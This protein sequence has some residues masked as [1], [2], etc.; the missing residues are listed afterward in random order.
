MPRR[1]PSPPV[2]VPPAVLPA[3]GAASQVPTPSGTPGAA[4][5]L[6]LRRE[7]AEAAGELRQRE[8]QIA[9]IEA[10]AGLG[11]WEQVLAP[12]LPAQP[13]TW[14]AELARIHGLEPGEA[15]TTFEAFLPLVHPEDRALVVARTAALSAAGEGGDELQYRVLRPDGELRVVR[16]RARIVPSG[17]GRPARMIGTSRD[18]TE[19]VAA[20]RALREREAQ[21]AEAQEIAALGHWEWD[22][23]ADRIAWSDMQFR[24]HGEEPRAQVT[25]AWFFG[26]VHPDDRAWMA[27][28]MERTLRSGEPFEF[29]YRIVRPSGEVRWL[30]AR[31]RMEMSAAGEPLRMVGT[32]QDITAQRQAEEA[33]RAGEER[34]RALFE[35]SNDAIL[36]TDPAS[37]EVVEANRRLLELCD[38]TL[39][40]LR[41]D[42]ARILWNGP[43]PYTPEVATDQARRAAAG[44]AQRFEW[45]TIQP[46]TGA[47]I[48]GEVSLQGLTLNGRALCLA[49]IRDIRARRLAEQALRESEES[50]R[51]IFDSS[52]DAVFVHEL[53]S[54]RVLDANRTACEMNGRTLAELR[55]GGL[56]LI[57]SGPP[58]FTPERALELIQKA[59]GGEAQR[60]EWCTYHAVTREEMWVEVSLQKVIIREQERLLAL[61]R[62]I[63]ERKQRERALRASEEAYRTIFE[64][65]SEGIW[66]HDAATGE[67]VDVNLAAA[68]MYGYTLQE[69]RRLTHEALNMPGSE[70]TP[71]RVAEYMAWAVAGETPRFEWMGRRKDG[72]AVWAEVTL[73]RV[74]VAGQ[75]RILAAA[76]DIT[77]RKA[78]EEALRQSEASYRN[79]FDSAAAGIWLHDLETGDFLDVNQTACEMYGYSVE[80]QKRVGLAGI[81]W[82]EP[83]YTVDDAWQY[84][85]R[86]IAGEPQR[87]PWRGRHRDGHEV[88]AEVTVRRETIGG[89][90][91]VLVTGRNIS[92]QKKAEDAL[93]RANE[94]LERRVAERTG[95]LAMLNRMLEQEIEE[96]KAAREELLTRTGELEAIFQT[97]PDLYFRLAADG[98]ILDYRTG[99][100]ALLLVSPQL[101]LGRRM[102]DVLPAEAQAA[103]LDGM[104][105]VAETGDMVCIEYALPLQDGAH[106]FEARL[107]PAGRGELVAVVRDITESKQAEAELVRQKAYFEQIIDS[108]DAGLAIFDATGRYEYVSPRAIPDPAV[109][110]WAIGKTIAEY[111]AY[112][113]LPASVIEPRLRS[114]EAGLASKRVTEFEQE[115][116]GP[117]GDTRTMLRRLLPML[118]EAGEVVRLIG[119]SV[120]ITDRKRAEAALRESEERFRRLIEN[121]SDI[122]TVMDGW[123]TYL[124]QSPSVH[125]VLGYRPQEMLGR[126]S[127]EFIHPDDAEAAR[128][129]VQRVLKQPGV[130]HTAE[131]RFRHADGSWRVLESTG[132]RL[133]GEAGRA[134]VVF[135][136]R[137]V[138]ERKAA[139]EAL[140]QAT[141]AAERANRAKSEF[142]S[143]MSHELRTPMNSI[144]GFAQLLARVELAPE[145]KRGV[146]HILKA[147]RHLLALINE[148]LEIARIEAGREHF[149]LE[150]VCIGTVVQEALALVRP[151]AAQWEVLL[152][153]ETGAAG[154]RYVH[155]DRQRLTQV[156]LNLLSN[157]IKYNRPGGRV[158]LT[159]GDGRDGRVAVRVADTG[160]GIAAERVE[161][162]FT[163]F[164]RLGAEQ[165]EVEGTGL[166]LAL[167]QRLAEA[168]GGALALESSGPAGSVFRLEVVAAHDP[169]H[170]LEA[171]GAVP[172]ARAAPPAPEHAATLLYVEDNL[173]N[174]SL[175]ETILLS[176]PAWRTVPALQGQLGIELAREHRP[177]LILLDLHLPDLPGEEVLRRLRGDART[178]H[179]P[180]VVISADATRAMIERLREAGADGYLT[181][182]LDVDEF[183]ATL[184]RFLAPAPPR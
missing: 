157:A 46:R 90:D 177:N 170:A 42:P 88:W 180:V 35:F 109:R 134:E 74:N 75:D 152:V 66:V 80:E 96:H 26:H 53:P 124:F 125:R 179:I 12:E 18:V 156:L 175:V 48:W 107:V 60:F 15:P 155:A 45:M 68:E 112:R 117:G 168:M 36:V 182:P 181:K 141:A 159:C 13:I 114:L 85:R 30:Q 57:G 165:S 151:L 147:G 39:A 136:S 119:Y 132:Q 91:R 32:S 17:A 93:R 50:Y 29:C 139:E 22:V 44:E 184:E 142:L 11:S 104:R 87:F 82:G 33:L 28:L 169:L 71:E 9:E 77:A 43:P 58:P 2:D 99:N 161:Q 21:L 70:Y 55:E 166:G 127:L 49:V 178:A 149:S 31:G 8:Q 5:V 20:E 65:S 24:L 144:L 37:G 64:N 92:D 84:V 3:T 16:A 6:A 86:A 164:A 118:D 56:E 76:R 129:A 103:L 153:D 105:S 67:M 10:L 73:R 97:L 81:A 143:R 126:S 131:Y 108:V 130:V 158:R 106:D 79:I 162:L 154:A 51:A 140:R 1:S 145:H 135:N 116:E 120:D 59:A 102:Q 123:G 94:E 146:Q 25:Y 176:R 167:S 101:F 19:R 95:E 69:M 61:V 14:S 128:E 133:N 173:A 52:N 83:P 150:P 47:E 110:A 72:G 38:A 7:L 183:L 163:P 4:D 89:V 137:D 40:E 34:Y 121:A 172:A 138:T 41:A 174:L 100:A 23:V 78:A 122:I 148:V 98:T 63:R 54:G 171:S 115:M 160:R 113:G 62:D 111:G 27:P